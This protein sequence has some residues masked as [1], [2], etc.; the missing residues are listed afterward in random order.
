MPFWQEKHINEALSPKEAH[1]ANLSGPG[2]F[3][4]LA[5]IGVCQVF[6]FVV[7]KY[8]LEIHPSITLINY[9]PNIHLPVLALLTSPAWMN[10]HCCCCS[11]AKLCLTLCHPVDCSM[12]GSSVFHDHCDGCLMWIFPIPISNWQSLARKSWPF[13]PINF[14]YL[15]NYILMV[16][17]SLV[18]Q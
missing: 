17:T 3:W 6:P 15:L 2:S 12:P 13:S 9:S 1:D 18:V 16:T 8:F 14:S 5:Q 7:D 11:V 10:Q 4:T